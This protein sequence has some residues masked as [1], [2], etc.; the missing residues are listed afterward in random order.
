MYIDE[1]I[2]QAIFLQFLVVK[3]AVLFK[4]AFTSFYAFDGA[5]ALLRP[6]ISGPDEVRHK[7]H[8][9]QSKLQSL[10]TGRFF[11]SQLPD[12]EMQVDLA[13]EGE[14]EV[15]IRQSTSQQ[16]VQQMAVQ[17]P[18]TS[19]NTARQSYEPRKKKTSNAVFNPLKS[20]NFYGELPRNKSNIE[21][22]HIPMSPNAGILGS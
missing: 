17:L 1:D 10:Y 12:S 22:D 15:D 13:A 11:M 5:R 3:W 14:E 7:S 4:Q 6:G 9:I 21:T 8:S 20:H 18:P 2:L 19:Q 16:A